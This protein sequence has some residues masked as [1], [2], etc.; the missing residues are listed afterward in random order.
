MI[1]FHKTSKNG[2]IAEL[3]DDSC[4]IFELQD[5]IDLIA[6]IGVNDCNN[7]IIKEKMGQFSRLM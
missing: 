3:M 1:R 6:E 5:A 4:V 2:I 7:L